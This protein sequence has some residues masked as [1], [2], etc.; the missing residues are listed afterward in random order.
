MN[1]SKKFFESLLNTYQTG[2]AASVR[3]SD[4]IFDCVNLLRYKRGQNKDLEIAELYS[5]YI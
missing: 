1:L 5:K 4:F 2:L 3:S